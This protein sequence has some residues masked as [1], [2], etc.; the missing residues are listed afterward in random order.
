MCA[1]LNSVFSI[2][3]KPARL[4]SHRLQTGWAVS[5]G[6]FYLVLAIGLAIV[7]CKE[8]LLL[9][10]CCVQ[11]W[12]FVKS[13]YA[14]IREWPGLAISKTAENMFL[15]V[16]EVGKIKVSASGVP[17]EEWLPG[18]Q[19]AVLHCVEGKRTQV[20]LVSYK[21]PNPTTTRI[22]RPY[23]LIISCRLI[24]TY[25]IWGEAYKPWVE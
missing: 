18:S 19:M 5:L 9:F 2:P 7:L 11:L 22:P 24:S 17:A 21:G 20:S 15:S 14:A 25:K 12:V 3:G 16:L 6:S 8:P 23:L 4:P 10:L 13:V 1:D